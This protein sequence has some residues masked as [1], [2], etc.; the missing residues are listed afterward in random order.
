MNIEELITKLKNTAYGIGYY[1]VDP[2]GHYH[3]NTRLSRAETDEIIKILKHY[4]EI[5]KVVD[6]WDNDIFAIQTMKFYYFDRIVGVF[7]E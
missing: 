2:E 5:R 6:E 3:E 4:A 1:T 7:K